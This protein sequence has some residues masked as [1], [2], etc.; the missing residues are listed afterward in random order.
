MDTKEFPAQ[1]V[2][3]TETN[4]EYTGP[5]PDLSDIDTDNIEPGYSIDW[6]KAHSYETSPAE[7]ENTY[8]EKTGN[9]KKKIIAV[10][11]GVALIAAGVFTFAT[12]AFGINNGNA[13]ANTAPNTPPTNITDTQPN[14]DTTPTKSTTETKSVDSAS[15]TE[16]G[17]SNTESTP[18][19]NG[20]KTEA[21]DS[22]TSSSVETLPATES[23]EID[24]SL[25]ESNPEKVMQLFEQNFVINIINAGGN[26]ENAKKALASGDIEK[27]MIKVADEEEADIIKAFFSDEAMSSPQIVNYLKK[28]RAIHEDVL[29]Y[30]ASTSFPNLDKT[31]KEPYAITGEVTKVTSVFKFSNGITNVGM[32]EIKHDNGLKTHYQKSM[33]TNKEDLIYIKWEDVNGK[34]KVVDVED[35]GDAAGQNYL[36]K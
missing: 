24:S 30:N 8:D 2:S 6:E 10:A 13:N 27:Y 7:S 22:Q 4:K 19:T 12:N 15:K 5:L 16:T 32:T 3:P 9:R 21:Q 25:L 14:Y 35:A 23:L 26:K 33:V 34:L 29:T 36:G 1:K 18:A 17:T 31:D 20:A 11:S 28:I